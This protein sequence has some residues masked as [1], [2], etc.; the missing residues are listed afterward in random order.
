MDFDDSQ[1]FLVFFSFFSFCRLIAG[2]AEGV[3]F[4][5]IGEE[6][7][8]QGSLAS[9][10]TQ[11][12]CT[13]SRA[14]PVKCLKSFFFS[15]F[16]FFF[17]KGQE[18]GGGVLLHTHTDTHTHKKNVSPNLNICSYG[19]RQETANL[20]A[21]GWLVSSQDQSDNGT[22]KVHQRHT[23]FTIILSFKHDRAARRQ[24]IATLS[25]SLS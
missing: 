3:T 22:I 17:G 10:P 14:H 13:P 15:F 8:T 12:S 6:Q 24:V 20:L 16:F 9:R 25:L 23:L 19:A 21:L 11:F 5:G 18:K 1:L 7:E 4:V 2:A